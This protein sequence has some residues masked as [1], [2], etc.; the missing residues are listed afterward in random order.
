MARAS[1]NRRNLG[2][3]KARAEM[4]NF[5]DRVIDEIG[6]T[7]AKTVRAHFVESNLRIYLRLTSPGH[8]LTLG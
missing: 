6:S 8:P 7:P 4:K 2:E 1:S 5:I 3:Q